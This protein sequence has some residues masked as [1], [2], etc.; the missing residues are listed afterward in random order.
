MKVVGKHTFEEER[1]KVEL[2]KFKSELIICVLACIE[3]TLIKLSIV[4][5]AIEGKLVK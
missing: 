1:P 2:V 3:N 5:S 4:L